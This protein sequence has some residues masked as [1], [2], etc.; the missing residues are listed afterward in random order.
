MEYARKGI[1]QNLETVA[2]VWFIAELLNPVVQ[3]PNNSNEHSQI[4]QKL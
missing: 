3:F 2:N 1:A 4:F